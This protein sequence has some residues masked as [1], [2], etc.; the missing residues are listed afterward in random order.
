MSIIISSVSKT[1]TQNAVKLGFHCAWISVFLDSVHVFVGPTRTSIRNNI[2]SSLNVCF[3]ASC[4]LPVLYIKVEHKLACW[5][6]L[7]TSNYKLE[8]GER[9][10]GECVT[11]ISSYV[12]YLLHV[13]CWLCIMEQPV[14]L[15]RWVVSCN[16][17]VRTGPMSD[18]QPDYSSV[19]DVWCVKMPII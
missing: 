7:S 16:M 18:V 5:C 15:L 9:S 17:V 11:G 2:K 3:C 8:F 12:V 1:R 19:H 4:S 13:I 14:E 10:V 6:I